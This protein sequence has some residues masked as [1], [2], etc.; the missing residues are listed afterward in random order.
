MGTTF[1]VDQTPRLLYYSIRV[2]TKQGGDSEYI[3]HL[4]WNGM[5]LQQHVKWTWYFKYRGALLRIK[6]P[7]MHIEETWGKYT[8]DGRKFEEMVSD[9]LKKNLTTSKRMITK[10]KNA[11]AHYEKIEGAKLFPNWTDAKYLRAK[12][13]LNKYQLKL[14]ELQNG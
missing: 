3:T 10:M 13:K 6:Y 2:S 12:E 1:K 5:T 4:F 8:P 9:K 14:L 11:I 7:R